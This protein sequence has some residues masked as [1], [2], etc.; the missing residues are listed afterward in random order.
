MA[1]ISQHTTFNKQISIAQKSPFVKVQ[2]GF[3]LYS[4]QF[5]IVL[6]YGGDYLR[7]Q[8]RL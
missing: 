3:L 8:V 1:K 2:A 6:F 4:A 7:D 5:L